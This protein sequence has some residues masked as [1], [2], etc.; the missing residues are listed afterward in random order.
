MES[1]KCA[2]LVSQQRPSGAGKPPFLVGLDGPV[3]FQ[4]WGIAWASDLPSGNIFSWLSE[5]NPHVWVSTAPAG[6]LRKQ[7]TLTPLIYIPQ[8]V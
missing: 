5:I 8:Q 3:S 1:I 6:A 7:C 2:G 4:G